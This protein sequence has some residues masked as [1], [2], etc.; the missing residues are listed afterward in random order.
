MASKCYNFTLTYILN[1]ALLIGVQEVFR[2][3]SFTFFQFQL[4]QSSSRPSLQMIRS[5]SAV[6]K[7][8]KKIIV[9]VTI[10]EDLGLWTYRTSL[11]AAYFLPSTFATELLGVAATLYTCIREILLSNLCRHTSYTELLCRLPQSLQANTRKE[12]L[13]SHEHSRPHQIN[14]KGVKRELLLP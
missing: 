2:W 11:S 5:N 14:N 3:F 6:R 9:V 1:T 7:T 13:L 8:I 10:I 12:H 4:S